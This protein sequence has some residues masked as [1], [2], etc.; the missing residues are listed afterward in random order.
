MPEDLQLNLAL[1]IGL[2]I[3]RMC[4]PLTE[5]EKDQI[6][7]L[8]YENLEERIFPRMENTEYIVG[9]LIDDALQ[10]ARRW[11]HKLA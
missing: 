3:G 10:V 5:Q 11:H 9:R 4:L 8:A 2:E 6:K 1:F 7:T